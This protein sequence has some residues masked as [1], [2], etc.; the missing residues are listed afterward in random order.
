M[1]Q[2]TGYDFRRNHNT[3]RVNNNVRKI[4][5]IPPHGSIIPDPRH[6][7]I[8]R[9]IYYFPPPERRDMLGQWL[10]KRLQD[11]V[12]YWGPVNTWREIPSEWDS[13][14]FGIF[15]NYFVLYF[16]IIH[17]VLTVTI[18]VAYSRHMAILAQA[19]VCCL[20]T[21]NHYLEQCWLISVD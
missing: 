3:S 8:L 20:T 10:K 1:S 11:R 9:F 6:R 19:K 2:I 13:F 21:P 15:R 4:I 12:V 5:A 18:C 14:V 16:L 17:W 7:F